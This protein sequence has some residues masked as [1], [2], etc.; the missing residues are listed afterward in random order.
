MDAK[1][2]CLVAIASCAVAVQAE[3]A[4]IADVNFSE[5]LAPRV[6]DRGISISPKAKSLDGKKV[7]IVGFMVRQDDRKPGRF[8][9]A[10]VPVQLHDEHYGLA[11]DLPATTIF[12]STPRADKPVI[13]YTPAPLTVTGVF[14]VGNHEEPDGRISIFRME[15]DAPAKRSKA[16]K[17]NWFSR[18]FSN[19]KRTPASSIN[20]K[21][22]NP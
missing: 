13:Q 21:P 6:G 9:I 15:M 17:G 5:L 22:Q 16:A 12:V 4:K 1:T 18:I 7:R 8:L 2:F 19:S 20:S 10:P 14:S 11:D 3:S